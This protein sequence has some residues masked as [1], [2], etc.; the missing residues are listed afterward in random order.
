MRLCGKERQVLIHP[1]ACWDLF[2]HF[3]KGGHHRPY[4]FWGRAWGCQVEESAC[5]RAEALS[6]WQ[7]SSSAV[8][9]RAR[10]TEARIDERN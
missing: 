4:L 9:P 10:A 8:G 7:I 1:Q 3:H 6:P 2:P 5:G